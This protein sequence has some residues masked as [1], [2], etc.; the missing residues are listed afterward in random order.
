[1]T[2]LNKNV[3]HNP[4]MSKVKVSTLI[5]T[6]KSTYDATQITQSVKIDV[7]TRNTC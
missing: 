5:K 3:K 7:F 4:G 6:V 1:M 2:I